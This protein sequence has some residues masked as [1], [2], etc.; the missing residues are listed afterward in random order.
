MDVNYPIGIF[1]SGIGGVSVW[2]EI[3]R[4]LPGE[5]TVYF[6]DSANCPYGS[7]PQ[8]EIISLSEKNTEF[9]LS[10]NCKIIVVACN[11]ATAGAI[12]FLRSKYPFI[13]F[14]G[15]EPAVK[16]A[17]SHSKTNNIGVLAT[18]AT[19]NGKLFKETSQKYAGDVQIHMKAGKG[20]VELVESGQA[21]SEE[22]ESLL[23]QYIEPMMEQHIDQ[24]VLGCTHYPFL[25]KRIRTITGNNVTIINPAC[26]VA[27][28]VKEILAQSSL[29]INSPQPLYHDFY[30]NGNPLI[31]KNLLK[32]L[33]LLLEVR[34]EKIS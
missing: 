25:I 19:L 26:A 13:P 15:M 24:L 22:A 11:T 14:I 5:S 3:V 23:R 9:L 2:Q 29:L 34:V 12:E 21:D 6:A 7:R 31:L 18:E 1:D 32:N 20:L 33:S 10:K 30:T 16:P 8:H 27:K 28:H 17:V 4:Q